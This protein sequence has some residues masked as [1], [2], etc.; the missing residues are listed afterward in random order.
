MNLDSVVWSVVAAWI[1]AKVLHVN[2]KS[3]I[4]HSV[5]VRRGESKDLLSVFDLARENFEV[6]GELLFNVI[7][8]S[9]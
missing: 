6:E 9:S 4:Q 5:A 2:L 1:V 8:F 7:R 3:G